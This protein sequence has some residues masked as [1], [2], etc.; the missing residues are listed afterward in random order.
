M[1]IV[2]VVDYHVAASAAYRSAN[3]ECNRLEA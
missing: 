1:C 3:R 2:G